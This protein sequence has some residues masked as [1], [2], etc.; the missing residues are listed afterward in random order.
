MTEQNT[1]A[2][3]TIRHFSI[4]RFNKIDKEIDRGATVVIGIKLR[5]MQ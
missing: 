2:K 3:R 5:A 1:G 4:Q